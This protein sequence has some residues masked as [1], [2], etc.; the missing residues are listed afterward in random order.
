MKFYTILIF[1]SIL[2]LVSL[3]AQTQNVGLEVGNTAPEISLPDPSGKVIKLSDLRG[4]VVFLDFWAS[5][6]LPCR[7]ENPR[8]RKIYEKYNKSDF[9]TA[10]GFEVYSVSLD[11]NKTDW[12]TAINKDK[13]EW[14]A[15]VSELNHWQSSAAKT[16]H[17]NAIPM[18]FL[19]DENGII[20]A[21]GLNSKE[22]EEKLETLLK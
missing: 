22:L 13:L 7:K 11:K 4:N 21:K 14:S 6:C 10:K 5:W 19:I 18:N 17:I 15:H 3:P 16:Y 1:A 9:K 8:I 12:T 20:I 2:F